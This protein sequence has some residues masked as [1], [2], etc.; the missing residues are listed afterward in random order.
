[1]PTSDFYDFTLKRRCRRNSVS[2]VGVD[3]HSAR[4]LVRNAAYNVAEDSFSAVGVKLYPYDILVLYAQFFGVGG[5]KVNVPLGNDNT[6]LDLNFAA[7]TYKLT[8]GRTRNVAAFADRSGNAD[9]TRVGSGKLDLG[10]GT[11]RSEDRNVCKGL[12]GSYDLNAF[13]TSVL[14]GLGKVFLFSEGRALAEKGLK[15]LLS[16]VNVTC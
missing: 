9:R 13:F 2:F 3:V 1:M 16:N 11:D 10:S 12:F 15:I 7:G 6:L 14:T 5:S 8:S 4:E